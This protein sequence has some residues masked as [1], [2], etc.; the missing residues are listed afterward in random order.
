[1]SNELKPCPFCGS[2]DVR[3]TS[4]T[5]GPLRAVSVVI[6]CQLCNAS[7]DSL[8]HNTGH[9]ERLWNERASEAY[10]KQLEN[11]LRGVL[12]ITEDSMG[13]AGYHQNGDIAAWGEFSEIEAAEMLL[14]SPEAKM[15]IKRVKINKPNRYCRYGVNNGKCV[16]G[17]LVTQYC[18][19]CFNHEPF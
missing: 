19:C 3:K 17:V 10:I 14:E 1:M 5:I 15:K 13:V 2:Q 8:I 11:A 16:H 6:R 18:E 7:M 4:R 9:I 12:N